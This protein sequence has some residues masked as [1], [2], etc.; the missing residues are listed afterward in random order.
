MAYPL[1]AAGRNP[2]SPGTTVEH[3]TQEPNLAIFGC[4]VA[5]GETV[6]HF[7]QEPNLAIF[8]CLVAADLNLF[9]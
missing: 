1:V 4:L 3:F 2:L 9:P 8:G 7:T 5:A 6:E